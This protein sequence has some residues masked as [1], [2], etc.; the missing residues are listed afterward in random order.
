M[1]GV[2][3]AL[4]FLGFSSCFSLLKLL[5]TFEFPFMVL[6]FLSIFVSFC[7]LSSSGPTIHQTLIFLLN[8]CSLVQFLIFV[9]SLFHPLCVELSP[10]RYLV[11]PLFARNCKKKKPQTS[12]KLILSGIS[13]LIF[14]FSSFVFFL[15][16]WL[17]LCGLYFDSSI[18]NSFGLLI[19]CEVFPP[20]LLYF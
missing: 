18:V 19:Q 16:V 13:L 3:L 15:F 9:P 7:L 10:F 4:W 20:K 2:L 6:P 14:Y 1:C 5:L 11:G 8:L 12:T 17:L